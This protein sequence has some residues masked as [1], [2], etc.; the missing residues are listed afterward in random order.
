MLHELDILGDD[1]D[2]IKILLQNFTKEGSQHILG[3][4][5]AM[6]DDYLD[7]RENLHAL[8]GGQR[9]SW[10]PENLRRSGVEA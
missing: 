7:Y 2:F 8:K 4:K 1:P 5:K 6:H 3:I 10:A 9:P